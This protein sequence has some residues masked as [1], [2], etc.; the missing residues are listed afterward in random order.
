M[1][2]HT[3]LHARHDA[4]AW[5]HLAVEASISGRP[6]ASLQYASCAS[7]PHTYLSA[8]QVLGEHG[9]FDA[10]RHI[11]TISKEDYAAALGEEL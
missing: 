3:P 1:T 10:V 9:D 11:A 5:G 6:C 8:C 2:G 4:I 7:L